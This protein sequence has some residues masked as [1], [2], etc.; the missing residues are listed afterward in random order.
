[1][2]AKELLDA[3][4]LSTAIEQLNADVK[5]H[6]TDTR[7]RTFLFELLCFTGDYQCA[8][9]Q[10]EV[11]SSQSVTAE[12][13][14]QVY[15][16]ILEAEKARHRLF[17]E[18]LRPEFLLD[19]PAYVHLHLAAGNRIR[20]DR[21]VE[22]KALLEQSDRSLMHCQGQFEGRSFLDFRD[23]HD[24]IGPF[25]EVIVQRHYVWL[26]FEQIKSLKILSPQR[27]RDLLWIPA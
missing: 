20:E 22:A 11:L 26:P 25:L 8:E 18:G 17:T 27:L 15:R 9:R 7:L 2:K 5:S 21:L 13:G 6:P 4:H 12:V 16:N 23:A 3:G 19:P 10:L 1:M 14:G 24:L